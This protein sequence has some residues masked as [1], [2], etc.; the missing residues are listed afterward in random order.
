MI[1]CPLAMLPFPN[2][3][4]TP[5][6]GIGWYVYIQLPSFC[7]YIYLLLALLKNKKF[8][9][10]NPNRTDPNDVAHLDIASY[11]VPRSEGTNLLGR[12]GYDPEE[13]FSETGKPDTARP[14][15]WAQTSQHWLHLAANLEVWL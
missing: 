9:G 8:R 13:F 4:L 1:L 5:A 7:I 14:L 15:V 11:N 10:Q 6:F 2:N 3:L 12:I